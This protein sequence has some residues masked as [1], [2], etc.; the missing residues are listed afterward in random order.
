MKLPFTKM[1]GAG[2]DFVV[3]DAT[4]TPFAPD[5]ALLRTLTDRRFGVGCDQVL[6]LEPARDAGVDFDFRIFN[7][8]AS[9]SG[10]C[11]NGAPCARALRARPRAVRQGR[12][13]RAHAHQRARAASRGRRSRAREH[14]RA[15][16]RAAEIPF[17][18]AARAPIYTLCLDD[19]AGSRS[20]AGEHGQ[21]ARD[22]RGRRRRRRA[23]GGDRARAASASGVPGGRQRR[24]PSGHLAG[25]RRCAFTSAARARRWRAAAA[26]ARR[27]SPRESGVSWNRAW[28]WSCAAARSP[29]SGREASPVWMTG[30]ATEVYQGSCNGRSEGP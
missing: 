10:Q 11:G 21:P 23:G 2:N 8:D 4:R 9:E 17:K 15:Q 16:A 24:L 19:G 7:A 28:T 18:A 26:P 22:H 25:A 29:S 30:P 20:A 12:D 14:G 13:S 6:V 1:H 27:S 3:I 5:A